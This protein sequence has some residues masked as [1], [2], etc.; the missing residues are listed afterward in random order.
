MKEIRA[1]TTIHAPIERVWQILTDADRLPDWNPF[2]TRMR[3]ELRRGAR[4][5]VR[6]RPPGRRAMTFRPVV[7]VA[8]PPHRLAWLGR[9]GLPGIFDGE[10]THTLERVDADTTRYVQSERFRGA[11]VP[12]TAGV[13]RATEAGFRA[14]NDALRERAEGAR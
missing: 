4:L 6:I 13:L 1:E 14:M 8:E 5:E 2:L 7:R 11:L 10:H 12:F 9:L 3:G